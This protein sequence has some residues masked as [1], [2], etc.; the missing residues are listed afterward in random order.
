[1]SV[2]M[3]PVVGLAVASVLGR[4]IVLI[5]AFVLVEHGEPFTIPLRIPFSQG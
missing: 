4:P 3:F 2:M 5:V 1:V